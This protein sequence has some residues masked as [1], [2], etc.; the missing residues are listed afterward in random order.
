MKTSPGGLH[1]FNVRILRKGLILDNPTICKHLICYECILKVTLIGMV[2]LE[3]E[4]A[5]NRYD[6]SMMTNK[7]KLSHT[8]VPLLPQWPHPTEAPKSKII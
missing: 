7:T 4:I 8:Y 2:M 6:D 5:L 3:I 1:F